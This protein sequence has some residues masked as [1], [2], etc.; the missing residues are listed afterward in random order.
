MPPLA[1]AAKCNEKL[2]AEISRNTTVIMFIVGLLKYPIL[3]SW[4]EKP[5]IATVEKLWAMASNAVIPANQKAKAQLIVKA[6]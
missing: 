5:P 3:A 1:K 2:Q 6:R 4:V